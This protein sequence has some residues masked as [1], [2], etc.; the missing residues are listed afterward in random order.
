MMTAMGPRFGTFFICTVPD[1]L[2]SKDSSVLNQ[3]KGMVNSIW[4][5]KPCQEEGAPQQHV[6]L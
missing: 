2:C 6:S 4:L 5:V 1:H 3:M